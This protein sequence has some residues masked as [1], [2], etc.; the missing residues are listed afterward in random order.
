[1]KQIQL[2]D[3]SFF[4]VLWLVPKENAVGGESYWSTIECGQ[5]DSM[6]DAITAAQG[7]SDEGFIC[8]VRKVERTV[9]YRV[10]V[11]KR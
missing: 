6:A 3:D 4:E 1:M 7:L 10:A 8:S 11:R 9:V 2:E 5:L